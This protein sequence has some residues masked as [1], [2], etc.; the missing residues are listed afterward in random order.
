[1]RFIDVIRIATRIFKNNRLRTFL[2]ILG[3]AVGIGT[4][5]FLIALGYGLQKLTIEQITSTDALTALEVTPSVGDRPRQIT[6]DMIKKIKAFDNVE[7]VEAV[8]ALN[9]QMSFDGPPGDVSV[10]AVSDDYFSLEGLSFAIG[11]KINTS[12]KNEAVVTTA[13]LDQ[14]SKDTNQLPGEKINIG[15]SKVGTTNELVSDSIKYKVV[16]IV[17]DEFEPNI[18]L[19]YE[20]VRQFSPESPIHSLKIKVNSQENIGAIKGQISAMGYPVTTVIDTV[21]QLERGFAV[22]RFVLGLLGVIA[23]IVA[24]IGMFNTLTISL[25]ERIKEVGIMKSLG[26][27]DKDIWQIFLAEA[28]LIGFCGGLVGL[29]MSFVGSSFINYIYNFLATSYQAQKVSLFYYPLWFVLM[30][31]AFACLVALITGFY[32]ARRAA[33][34]NPLQALRYE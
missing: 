4:I 13:L 31:L 9:G 25:L 27:S 33:K 20:N 11:G 3:V 12:A 22:V 6:D 7:T 14:F 10:Y 16:G 30:I 28:I 21:D 19:P 32:P 29:I 17:I 1:M 2:T 26:A 8:M 5:V 23:L 15:Y 24:S 34:L 18:Y